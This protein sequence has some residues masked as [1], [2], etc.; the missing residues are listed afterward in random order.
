MTDVLCPP[1]LPLPTVFGVAAASGAVHL[2]L[3][4]YQCV[5]GEVDGHSCDVEHV[6]CTDN[7]LG[8]QPMYTGGAVITCTHYGSCSFATTATWQLV[9]QGG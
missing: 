7:V 9:G 6:D 2:H 5:A 4:N 1:L 8:T 3:L